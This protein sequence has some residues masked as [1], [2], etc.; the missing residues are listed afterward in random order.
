MPIIIKTPMIQSPIFILHI[1]NTI[2]PWYPALNTVRHCNRYCFAHR[3]GKVLFWKEMNTGILC[4]LGLGLNLNELPNFYLLR[5]KNNSNITP[6][7]NKAAIP[8]CHLYLTKGLAHIIR[9]CDHSIP[10]SKHHLCQLLVV[11]SLVYVSFAFLGVQVNTGHKV[12]SPSAS[13]IC[14]RKGVQQHQ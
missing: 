11:P 1:T 14:T 3:S 10:S 13:Q 12:T 6:L 2:I 5:W 7:Q 9:K 8:A 4:G